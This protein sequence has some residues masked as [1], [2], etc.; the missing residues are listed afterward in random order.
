MP[1]KTS[2][3][4]FPLT[5]R[6]ATDPREVEG[7]VVNPSRFYGLSRFR[8]AIRAALFALVPYG[9]SSL[10]GSGGSNFSG[11]SPPEENT[12]KNDRKGPLCETGKLGQ[13]FEP[14]SRQAPAD[15]PTGVA[16]RNV[17]APVGSQSRMS[18]NTAPEW[19]HRTKGSNDDER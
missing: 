19:E 10:G 13:K 15:H 6:T 12:S 11:K 17:P 2:R 1:A 16:L 5:M 9:F 18:M 14:P 4:A 3:Q 8:A 7:V